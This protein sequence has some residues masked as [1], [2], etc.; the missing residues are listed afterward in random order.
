M[1]GDSLMEP[2]DY[3][4]REYLL[5]QD[6]KKAKE[7]A[8]SR[9]TLFMTKGLPASGKSTWAKEQV[10]LS[11]GK[12]KRVNKDD[13]RAMIDPLWTKEKEKAIIE[14]RNLIVAGTLRDGYNVIVDDTNLAPKHET[15]L[16]GQANMRDADFKV[17]SFL[18][19]SVEDCIKRDLGRP[20]AVGQNVILEMYYKY[21]CAPPVKDIEGLPS[22]VICDLDGTIAKST[23]RG[24]FEETRVYEDVVRSHVLRVVATASCRG[25][26]TF[27]SGRHD[28]CRKETYQWLLDK[29][30]AAHISMPAPFDLIMRATGDNRPDYIVKEELYRTHIEGKFNVAA[31]FDDRKCVCRMWS[32]IGLGDR[33][34]QVPEGSGEF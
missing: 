15:E 20:G 33:L 14:V 34:F 32:R 18:D 31:I 4:H 25:H 19:V 8:M 5:A 27:L 26:L 2:E 6:E 11:Q 23:G 16:R 29:A 22:T 7:K 10:A 9:P 21:L 28:S 24:P 1:I 17:V 30:G 3:A 13:L 12:T